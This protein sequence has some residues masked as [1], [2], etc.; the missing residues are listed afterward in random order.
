MS[1]PKSAQSAKL[2]IG[3]FM[4]DRDLLMPVTQALCGHFGG[5]DMVSAWMPFHHTN[6]YAAEMGDV[7]FRR[8]LVF[9]N[10]IEQDHLSDIKLKTN[11]IERMF[12]SNDKR[13]VNLDPGYILP[14]RFVLATGKNFT[15]RIYIGQGIYADLTLIYRKSGFEPLA[16]TYPDYMEMSMRSFLHQVR[17]NYLCDLKSQQSQP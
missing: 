5:I 15:H 10:L 8:M 3:L 9:R 6:Y 16:W 7:L 1:R 4:H 2:V 12:M 17:N 11:A 14:E 13:K